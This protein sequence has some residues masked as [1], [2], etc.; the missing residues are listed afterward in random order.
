MNTQKLKSE[1]A[2]LLDLSVEARKGGNQTLA[3]L[4]TDEAAK[5]LVQIADADSPHRKDPDE[6][7]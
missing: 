5:C 6:Q 1:L 7:S 3:K 2:S 4:L